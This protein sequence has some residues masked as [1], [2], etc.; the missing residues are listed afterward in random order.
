MIQFATQGS[1][2]PKTVMD[3][4]LADAKAAQSQQLID[5]ATSFM[6]LLV[7]QTTQTEKAAVSQQISQDL[8]DKKID[9]A[10]AT[11][12]RQALNKE[13]AGPKSEAA[14]AMYVEAMNDLISNGPTDTHKALGVRSPGPHDQHHDRHEGRRTRTRRS[15]R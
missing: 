1:V 15:M 9:Q 5:E 3:T 6:D 12:K 4:I 10:T 11:E 7:R 13:P 2:E 14:I 8:Y